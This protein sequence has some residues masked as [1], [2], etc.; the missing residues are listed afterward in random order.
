[1]TFIFGEIVFLFYWNLKIVNKITNLSTIILKILYT[2]NYKNY[3]LIN[4]I[5]YVIKLVKNK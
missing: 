4:E 5:I 3:I 1:M 2:K